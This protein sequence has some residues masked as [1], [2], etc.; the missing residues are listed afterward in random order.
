MHTRTHTHTHTHTHS[1]TTHTHTHS[2]TP[3]THT[4]TQHKHTLT[5][6]THACACARTQA[7]LSTSNNRLFLGN[8]PRATTAQELRQALEREVV[9][10]QLRGSCGVGEGGQQGTCGAAAGQAAG[11]S[12]L[13]HPTTQAACKAQVNFEPARHDECAGCVPNAL[14]GAAP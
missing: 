4:H 2:V 12:D 5:Q 9:G 7:S 10:E 8:V 3:H 11:E 1:D 6:H 13:K 14:A